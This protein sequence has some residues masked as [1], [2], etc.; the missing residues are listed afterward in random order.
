[1]TKPGRPAYLRIA[2]DLRDRIIGGDLAP[3]ELLPSESSLEAQY[4]KS[5]IVVRNAVKVLRSEGLVITEHGKGTRVR[6]VRKVIRDSA[7]RYSRNRTADVSPF[8]RDAGESGQ[9]GGWEHESVK[10]R[11]SDAIAQRLGIEAGDP[12]MRTNY[13]FQVNGEPVQISTSYEP[14]SLTENTSAEYPEDGAA[15]GVIARMDTVGVHVDHV[16]EKVNARAARPEEIRRLDLPAEGSYV[17]L[18]ERTHFAGETPV[19]TCDIVFPGDRY[20][21]NYRI[22]VD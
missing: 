3:D 22:D 11:A 9:R 1:M 21:L 10:T 19:E 12:V 2:D 18:I 13:L 17:L 6:S 15:V 20:E 8:K 5:R 4:K 16:I 7:G 14:L